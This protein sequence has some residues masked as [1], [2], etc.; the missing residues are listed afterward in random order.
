MP[1]Q[2]KCDRDAL[3]PEGTDLSG[4]KAMCSGLLGSMVRTMAIYVG[5]ANARG[6]LRDMESSEEFWVQTSQLAPNMREHLRKEDEIAKALDEAD[7]E[8]RA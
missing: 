3:W 5:T 8:R 4:M 7:S 6:I 2:E 1:T